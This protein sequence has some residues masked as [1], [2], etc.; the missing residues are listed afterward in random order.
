MTVSGESQTRWCS[1]CGGEFLDDVEDCPDCSIPLVASKPDDLLA[2]DFSAE[3]E[4]EY[5]LADWAAESRLMVQQLM[6]AASVPH[7]WQGTSLLVPAPFEAKADAVVDEVEA[8]LPPVLDPD[9]EK[10]AYELDG[11]SD[12]QVGELCALLDTESIPY[13]FDQDDDLVIEEKDDPRVEAIIEAMDLAGG[14]QLDPDDALVDGVDGA[15]GAVGAVG[16]DD[17]AFDD[18]DGDDDGEGD[19][20]DDADDD[21]E[22][23]D[24]EDD[25]GEGDDE[26]GE[27][28]NAADLL[29]DLFVAADRLKRRARDHEGVLSLV[30]NAEIA[31]GAALPY[32]F[33]PK[34]WADVLARVNEVLHL[35]E[36]D[37][38]TDESIEESAGELRDVL[39][40]FV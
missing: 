28:V 23:D 12:A 14:T 26:E 7:A 31:N 36:D 32:G 24:A 11:W 18:G 29:S 20:D 34:V 8:S 37:A 2:P 19:A 5:D 10:V 22:D 3:G 38:S 27:E 17:G 4:L 30:D 21:A 25:D 39:R 16:E 35:I 40:V 33:D 13:G 15:D 1:Q 6:Q 9:A